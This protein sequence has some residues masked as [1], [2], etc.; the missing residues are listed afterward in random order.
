VI[1][2]PSGHPE[3]PQIIRFRMTRLLKKTAFNKFVTPHSLRHT[4][5]SLLIEAGIGVKEIQEI[6][7]H[8]DIQTT[9]NIYAHMTNSMKEKT[10]QR[11]TEFMRS[12]SENL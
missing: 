11:F 1:A 7:G 6:L 2:K 3:L 12:L 5:T 4:T 10:S 8:K 9:M